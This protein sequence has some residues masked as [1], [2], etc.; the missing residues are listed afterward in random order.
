MPDDKI[1]RGNFGSQPQLHGDNFRPASLAGLM[2]RMPREERDDFTR[3]ALETIE[4]VEAK[5]RQLKSLVL[6]NDDGGDVA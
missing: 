4:E 2:P 1:V 3:Y 6:M 5:I